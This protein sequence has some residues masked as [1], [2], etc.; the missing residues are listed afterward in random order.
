MSEEYNEVLLKMDER[1]NALVLSMNEAK[2]SLHKR[3]LQANKVFVFQMLFAI[4]VFFCFYLIYENQNLKDSDLQLRYLKATNNINME[5]ASRLDTVFNV[6]RNE[7][8]MAVIR[9]TV[10]RR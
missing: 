7:E 8:E 10:G 2:L 9:Q 3:K 5:V 6:Y 1:A 4:A